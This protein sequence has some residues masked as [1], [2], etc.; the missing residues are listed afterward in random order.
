[1]NQ[2]KK[3]IEKSLNKE[4]IREISQLETQEGLNKSLQWNGKTYKGNVKKKLIKFLTLKHEKRLH[5]ELNQL[6]RV[7]S[8]DDFGGEFIITIEWKKSYMWGS[9]P[10]VSTNYGFEGSSIGGCGYCK[11]STAT[12]QALNSNLSILK[13]MYQKKENYLNSKQFLIDEEIKGNNEILGY[14]A[15]YGLLP[16]FSGGVGVTSHENIISRLGLKMR[17]ISSTKSTDVYLIS[18]VD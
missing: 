7:K 18:M 5:Q 3:L 4:L 16:S 14:G 2:L 8:S 9:N 6:E 11:L 17:S 12:A 10:R 13:L 15:G 1:M